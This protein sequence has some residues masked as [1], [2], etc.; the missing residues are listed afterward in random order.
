[1]N[2]LFN[3]NGTFVEIIYEDKELNAMEI[4]YW[5]ERGTHIVEL[6]ELESASPE[7]LAEI[8]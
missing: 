6:E 3:Y 1:M 4:R 5:G 7:D 8:A 2:E